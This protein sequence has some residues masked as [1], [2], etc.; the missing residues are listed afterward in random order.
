[1]L[2]G[3]LTEIN[4]SLHRCISV[5]QVAGSAHSFDTREFVIG[6]GEITLIPLEQN[7]VLA[8]PLQSYS[9]L[10]S[11]A[12]T[13]LSVPKRIDGAAAVQERAMISEASGRVDASEYLSP[14]V[15]IPSSHRRSLED[16]SASV[17]LSPRL[18]ADLLDFD[19]W[20][21]ILT[22]Y[23]RTM[24]VAVA[25]TDPEGRVLGQMSQCAAGLEAGSWRSTCPG[26]RM[27]LLHNDKSTLYRGCRGIANR[28]D[29]DGA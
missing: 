24:R 12:P 25:L 1:M 21:E 5:S 19:A 7:L 10:L 17:E 27:S 26:C 22:T 8:L 3:R 18:R 6:Q 14:A 13:R 29:G 16:E 28:R 23:G 9:S 15:P 20:G 4:N 2:S 11:R